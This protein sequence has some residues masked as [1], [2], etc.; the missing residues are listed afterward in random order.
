MIY[1]DL[2]LHQGYRGVD[3]K[4]PSV[5]LEPSCLL[6]LMPSACTWLTPSGYTNF[7]PPEYEK[8]VADCDEALNLDRQ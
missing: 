7:S 3:Q 1:A 2:K 4:G 5:L 6:V 8:C